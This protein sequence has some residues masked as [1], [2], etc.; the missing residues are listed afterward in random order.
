MIRD[1]RLVT[2]MPA[3]DIAII[4]TSRRFYIFM[5]R[6]TTLNLEPIEPIKLQTC[7]P[8]YFRSIK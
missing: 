1:W 4:Y 6:T 3:H 2:G 7:N 5:C 8:I